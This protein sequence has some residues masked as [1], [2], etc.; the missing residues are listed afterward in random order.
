MMVTGSGYYQIQGERQY[1]ERRLHAICQRVSF[2]AVT[3]KTSPSSRG[4]LTCT[5]LVLSQQTN[6]LS[7]ASEKKRRGKAEKLPVAAQEPTGD[8]LKRGFK[9]T[10][11]SYDSLL[12]YVLHSALHGGLAVDEIGVHR[13]KGS[14]MK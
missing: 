7:R 11:A 9:Y 5:S 3:L 1:K 12:A 4:S 14:A 8:H 6:N 2:Q 10:L 13:H